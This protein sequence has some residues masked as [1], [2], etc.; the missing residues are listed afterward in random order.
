MPRR[1]AHLTAQIRTN[2]RAPVAG[3]ATIDQAQNFSGPVRVDDMD[4]KSRST[5]A[6]IS[7]PAGAADMNGGRAIRGVSVVYDGACPI[8]RL[9]TRAMALRR[10]YG[11]L[12]L[13]DART[14]PEH[15]LCRMAEERGLDLDRGMLIEAGGRLYYGAEVT[16]F[17]ASYGDPDRV[18]TKL[19]R[20][21][22]RSRAASAAVYGLLRAVRR[23]LL[24]IRGVERL[25]K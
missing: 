21:L 24:V 9:A 14:L 11:T 18:M 12:T 4:R 22:G 10:E 6:E 25:G 23:V 17:L 13:V 15:R 16:L 2:I 8:C 19:A 20:C 5:V 7:G 1:A 3:R